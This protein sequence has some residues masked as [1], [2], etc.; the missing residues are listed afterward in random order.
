[1]PYAPTC[2]RTR[3]LRR[4]SMTH[5]L[6]Y[7]CRSI[8]SAY[9]HALECFVA[10]KQEFL[11]QSQSEGSSSRNMAH[12]YDFQHRY[13]TALLKQ[14]PPGTVYPAI[15]RPVPMHPPRSSKSP[16]VRQGPFLLQPSPRTIDGSEGGDATDI[17]YVAFGSDVEEGVEGETERLGLVLA[18]FQDGRVDVYLDV[19]KVEARWAHKEV[20]SVLGFL[21]CHSTNEGHCKSVQ[22]AIFPCSLCTRPSIWGLSLCSNKDQHLGRKGSS[23]CLR[24]TIR[25]YTQILSTK[26]LSTFTTPSGSMLSNS[27]RYSGAW[28]SLSATT[29]LTRVAHPLTNH[30]RKPRPPMFIPCCRLSTYSQGKPV[31]RIKHSAS[32]LR[33][34]SSSPVIGVSIPNDVYLTYS[35]FTLTAARR[36]TVFPLSLRSETPYL[37]PSDFTALTLSDKKARSPSPKP[38]APTSG[39]WAEPDNLLYSEVY[40]IPDILSNPTGLPTY[41][42]V[43]MPPNASAPLVITPETLRYLG[44]AVEQV[45]SLIRDV[46]RGHRIAETRGQLQLHEMLRQRQRMSIIAERV[47]RL[48]GEKRERTTRKIEALRTNQKAIMARADA[49]LQ[50]MVQRASP[51]LSENE[52]KWFEELRRMEAEVMGVGK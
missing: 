31:L 2:R 52:S 29:R 49:L 5:I 15:S 45:T 36:L 34:R 47:A 51:D 21:S 33:N 41:A 27:S 37:P 42:R 3:E 7:L 13:V 8:P 6:L 24:E 50:N 43:S 10:A 14:L 25:C 4:C 18:T 40:A 23:T 26:I 30:C 19:E 12:L 16:P 48:R 38:P 11:S 22:I 32:H 28:R 9:V 44:K 46:V 39:P 35:I 1:M 20:G 17:A